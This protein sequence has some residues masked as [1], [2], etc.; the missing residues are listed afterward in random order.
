MYHELNAAC[1]ESFGVLRLPYCSSFCHDV[2]LVLN[3]KPETGVHA[4]E[5]EAHAPLIR[6][7][8]EGVNMSSHRWY[9]RKGWIY[10]RHLRRQRPLHPRVLPKG[11][12]PTVTQDETFDCVISAEH[13]MK[14][15]TCIQRRPY[16]QWS[17]EGELERGFERRLGMSSG[18]V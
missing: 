5:I 15:L 11:N 13:R 4:R 14:K 12:L 3:E 6:F 7:H 18:G 10:L 9:E 2:R 8:R 1:V 16:Q 17:I